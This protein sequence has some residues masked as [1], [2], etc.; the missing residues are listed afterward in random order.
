[1][2]GKHSL[3]SA[4]LYM[5]IDTIIIILSYFDYGGLLVVSCNQCQGKDLQILQNTALV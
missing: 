4:Q 3:T 1:M 2:L 5:C